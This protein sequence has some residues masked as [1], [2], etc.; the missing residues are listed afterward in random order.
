MTLP[1]QLFIGVD[2]QLSRGCPAVAIDRAGRF[3]CTSWLD[4]QVG[5]PDGP[6][7]DLAQRL[8]GFVLGLS[9]HHDCRVV[10]G[11]DAPRAPLRA[12]RP[13]YWDGTRGGRWRAARAGDRGLGRHC[14]IVV[15]ALSLGRP[16]WTPLVTYPP[17]WMALGFACFDALTAL[18]P[19]VLTHE[20]FPSASYRLFDDRAPRVEVSLAGF[21]RGPKDMLDAYCAAATVRE[22]ALGRGWEAGG[23]DGLGSIV[24][25]GPKRSPESF[26]HRWPAA[27]PP[28]R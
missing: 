6:H 10:V 17:D 9:D 3:I 14:E 11:V 23:G 22:H 4:V 13:Y 1:P 7:V 15:S 19:R 24:L 8:R 27:P 16:Q 25:P 28:G 5:A 18:G 26:V 12:H 21:S 20:V 2:V